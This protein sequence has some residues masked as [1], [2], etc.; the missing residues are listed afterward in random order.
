MGRSRNR[1]SIIDSSIDIVDF[2]FS[3]INE[4][5]K[6]VNFDHAQKFSISDIYKFASTLE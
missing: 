2:V 6:I 3:F 1:N 5:V 4:Y